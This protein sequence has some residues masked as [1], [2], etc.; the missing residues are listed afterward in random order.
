MHEGNSNL[1]LDKIRDYLSVNKIDFE[2]HELIRNIKDRR[3]GR[4]FTFEDNIKGLIYAQLSN[5]TKWVNIA[6]KLSQIDKLFFS[7]DKAK[8]TQIQASYFYDGIFALKCGNIAT[9][10][11]MLA[12]HENILMLEQI[13]IEYGTLDHF[14]STYPADEIAKLLSGGKYKLKYMGYALAWEFLRNVGVDGAKPDLHMRRI[15]GS[16]RLSYSSA[17]IASEDDV[18]RIVDGISAETGYYKSYIDNLLW[19]YCADGYGEIC[20]A[21]P[22]CAV[23]IVKE[24]CNHIN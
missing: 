3:N 19:S 1:V 6:T 7:F 11:Q 22:K 23:C 12:L 21:N 16:D 4:K 24:Y 18:I 13:E 17:A 10:K 15:F 9:K 5:Q 8:I 20:T 14:Y 2:N